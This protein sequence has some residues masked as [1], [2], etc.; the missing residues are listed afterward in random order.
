MPEGGVLDRNDRKAAMDEQGVARQRLQYV[1]V[2]RDA[3]DGADTAAQLEEAV[4]SWTIEYCKRLYIAC[5]WHNPVFSKVYSWKIRSVSSNVP[6]FRAL[7]TD[8]NLTPKDVP[9]IHRHAMC[10]KLWSVVGET[11]MRKIRFAGEDPDSIAAMTDLF[12]CAKCKQRKCTYMERQTRSADE[13][14]TVFVKCLVC[15]HSWKMS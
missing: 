13:A 5:T 8:G 7:L 10:P 3:L 6:N 1:N 4:Y 15:H 2:L 14:T 9:Y 12:K 11:N